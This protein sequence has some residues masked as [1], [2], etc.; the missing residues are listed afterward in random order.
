MALAAATA[1]AWGISAPSF[2][3]AYVL[4]AVAI[5][6]G[7]RRARRALAD[8]GATGP[9]SDL[10][11]RPHDVAHLAGG[12][13][14]AVWSALCALHVRGRITATDGSVQ[15]IG[16]LDAD[17]DPLERA[18]HATAT[19]GAGRRRLLFHHSVQTVL[20]A[21][22]ERLVAAGF[23]LSED[24]RRRIRRVGL[25]MLAVALVGLGRVLAEI[26]QARPVGPLLA[27][28]AA[29]TV[30]ALAQLTLAPRRSRSGDRA[31][32]AL[33]VEHR[34]LAPEHAPDLRA[35][36]PTGAALGIGLFGTGALA[37]AAPG[38]AR[39]VDPRDARRRRT[40]ATGLA[41]GGGGDGG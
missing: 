33:R 31:L 1:D 16:R 40:G 19:T 5:G 39:A 26:S 35:H 25:W 10:T 24:R 37:T 29:V 6:V 22:E 34:A 41:V 17:A 2:L 28:L 3:S 9:V 7:G 32:A 20:S 27:A 18:V 12:S 23:L 21:T 13:E 4:I 8:P 15:A 36:G 38:F 11:T 30:V 14:L